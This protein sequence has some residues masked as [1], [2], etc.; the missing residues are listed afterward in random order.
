MFK[1]PGLQSAAA[2]QLRVHEGSAFSS[3]QD[4][5]LGEVLLCTESLVY[6]TRVLELDFALEP[7]RLAGGPGCA[8]PLQVLRQRSQ[9][10]PAAAA[11]ASMYP[12]TTSQ[13]FEFAPILPSWKA[14]GQELVSGW[15]PFSIK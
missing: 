2:L 5:T 1:V 6:T 9:A 10:D 13:I 11:F 12:S 15:A 3:Q 14:K 7:P 4:S 8:V